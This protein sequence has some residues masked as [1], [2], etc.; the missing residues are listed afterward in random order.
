MPAGNAAFETSRDVIP[1]DAGRD[2]PIQ[3]TQSHGHAGSTRGSIFSRAK[4]DRRVEQGHHAGEWVN[5]T[6]TRCSAELRPT[7]LPRGTA[8]TPP[9]MGAAGA[10]T[11]G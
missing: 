8:S 7:R 5:M 2:V 3:M 10:H 1:R 6:G 11:S 9:R 4:M